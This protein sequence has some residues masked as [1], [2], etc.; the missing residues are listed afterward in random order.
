MNR[1]RR[2]PRFVS[3]SS[4]SSAGPVSAVA[5]LE[6][7]LYFE[8]VKEDPVGLVVRQLSSRPHLDSWMKNGNAKDALIM[9]D[10]DGVLG[11]VSRDIFTELS[12]KLWCNFGSNELTRAS[13][14]E[15]SKLTIRC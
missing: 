8:T 6:P 5:S 7:K 14:N 3:A 13:Y 12:Y 2:R 4:S 15:D 10:T 11:K 9:I 1:I